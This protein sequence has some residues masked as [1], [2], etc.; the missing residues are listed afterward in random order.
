M[1]RR[2]LG[3][4]SAFAALLAAGS[5]TGCQPA[6]G[7]VT[8][9]G[10]G[11]RVL[12]DAADGQDNVVT[13]SVDAT[14]LIL[15]DA[16]DEVVPAGRCTKIDNHSARCPRVGDA[17]FRVEL[18]LGDGDDR[19]TNTTSEESFLANGG[20]GDDTLEG[21]PDVD[22][23]TGGA[24]R[25]LLNG[26]GGDDLLGDGS[27]DL[28]EPDVFN[29]GAGI[30]RISYGGEPV[31]VTVDLDGVADDGRAGEFDRVGA[32]VEH[33]TGGQFPDRLTGNAK[34]NQLF[35]NGGDD[36]LVG[37]AGFDELF[38]GPGTDAC[39]LG[40]GGGSAFNCEA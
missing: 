21:G 18:T 3:I 35:G 27:T 24:G 28:Q 5:M 31:G 39:D 26:N 1:R 16:A 30:D 15:T 33:I 23:F 9:S 34:A 20:D 14:G 32:D 25:D 6:G 2:A 13:V 40:R 8:T 19:A 7:T 22:I 37:L 12:F 38:G 29:G 4:G 10:D 11:N 36:V 17:L